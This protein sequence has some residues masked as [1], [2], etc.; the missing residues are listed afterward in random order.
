MAD[1]VLPQ[2]GTSISSL[3]RYECKTR[4]YGLRCAFA[5]GVQR[6]S[7]LV[8]A[9][10]LPVGT[11][12]FDMVNAM[13]N[14]VVQAIHKL[15]LPQW[16]PMRGLGHW[17]DYSEHTSGLREQTQANFGPSAKRVILSVAHGCTVPEVDDVDTTRWPKVLSVESRLL[18]W[19]ACSRFVD[20][21]NQF[22]GENSLNTP[23]SLVGG[24]PCWMELW[25]GS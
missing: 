1:M 8:R 23:L 14:L 11:Q 13:T 12:D 18:R 2:G 19:V 5:I 10:V 21:H 7:N 20:L 6:C 9:N 15:E 16:L 17:R 24:R 4:E 22:I 3:V 25:A